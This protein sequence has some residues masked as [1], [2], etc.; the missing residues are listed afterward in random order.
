GRCRVEHRA[1]KRG[2]SDGA[3]AGGSQAY[4]EHT[5]VLSGGFHAVR[6]LSYTTYR[7]M[8]RGPITIRPIVAADAAAA[9]ALHTASWRSA[10]RGMLRH[11]YLDGDISAERRHV[12]AT[13]L[14]TPA[15]TNY[16]FIAEA[17]AGPVG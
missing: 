10:Y 11:E 13:R 8:D 15:G 1:D 12:W 5:A 4:P 3:Q 14:E 7:P 9:A 6:P 17:E 2:G 16:G